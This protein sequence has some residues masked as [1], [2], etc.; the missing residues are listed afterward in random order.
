ML[1]IILGAR[2]DIAGRTSVQNEASALGED[3]GL[4]SKGYG[5]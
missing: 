5:K 2:E 1:G 4:S 3:V